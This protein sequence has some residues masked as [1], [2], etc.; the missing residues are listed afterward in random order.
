MNKFVKFRVKMIKYVN[1]SLT[2]HN[3]PLRQHATS[4]A[5]LRCIYVSSISGFIKTR[6][7]I[8]LS[9]VLVPATGI[10]LHFRYKRK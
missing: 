4:N 8:N 5:R 9:L 10:D 6:E 2:G 1:F 7:R 3:N